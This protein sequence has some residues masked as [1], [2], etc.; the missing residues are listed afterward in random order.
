MTEEK[1]KAVVVI[2]GGMDSATLL[3]A[4]AAHTS[5]TPYAISFNYGQRHFRELSY[6]KTMCKELGVPHHVVD[7]QDMRVLLPGSALTDVKVAVPNGHYEDATMQATVVPGRNAIMLSI[8]YAYAVAIGAYVVLIGVHAGDHTVYPDCRPEFIDAMQEAMM[9]ACEDLC[10]PLP[11]IS[12]PYVMMTKADIITSGAAWK[13]PYEKTWSCYKGNELHCGK[14]G[15][16]VE[17]QEA[18][19][20]A[21]VS[22]PTQYVQYTIPVVPLEE[23]KYGAS[24]NS[25]D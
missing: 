24:T 17:R 2:S 13:V 3:Y 19:K 14:C 25:T 23:A 16:C 18:F 9:E 10:D 20:L 1:A 11:R 4:T 15:T 22:D 6:A 7:L 12:A 5:Y 8:A 21:D